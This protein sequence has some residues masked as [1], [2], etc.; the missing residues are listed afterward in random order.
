[1]EFTV[2][3]HKAV[4]DKT[5]FSKKKKKKRNILIII[6]EINER[7]KSLNEKIV[8]AMKNQFSVTDLSFS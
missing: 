5:I 7:H 3:L 8:I 2:L 6:L 4:T 1:M